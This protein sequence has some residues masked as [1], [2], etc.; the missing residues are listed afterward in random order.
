MTHESTTTHNW[1][2]WI[3]QKIVRM[4]TTDAGVT[5]I[6]LEDGRGIT[7]SKM[8]VSYWQVE[9]EMERARR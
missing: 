6:E 5:E 3:G 8:G 7:F 2:V 4:E 9:P 1:A